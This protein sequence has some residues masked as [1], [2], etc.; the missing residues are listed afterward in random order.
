MIPETGQDKSLVLYRAKEFP[1]K[2]EKMATLITEIES[3]DTIVWEE[4]KSIYV[5]A[6]V[7]L[8]NARSAKNILYILDDNKYQLRFIKELETTGTHGIRNAGLLFCENGVCYRPGQ[9]CDDGEYG[10]GL[11]MWKVND[12]TEKYQEDIFRE[13]NPKDIKIDTDCDYCG[14]H[15]YNLSSRYEVVDLKINNRNSIANRIIQMLQ[16]LIGYILHK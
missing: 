8:G 5:L 9:N 3:S 13:V 11:I 14:I 6:S 4:D 7:L 1:Y 2:W 12:T 16:I 10:K 15:T